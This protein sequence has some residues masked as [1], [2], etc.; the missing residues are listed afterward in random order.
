M[1][2]VKPQTL[3]QQQIDAGEPYDNLPALN[4]EWCGA[5]L[6]HFERHSVKTGKP[7]TTLC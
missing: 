6:L 5:K 2:R 1:R 3:G 7:L 4:C